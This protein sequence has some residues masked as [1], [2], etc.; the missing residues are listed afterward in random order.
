[1]LWAVMISLCAA[2]ES[3][4]NWDR[5]T[6]RL[7]APGGIYGRIAALPD[8]TLLCGYERRGACWVMHSADAGRSWSPAVEAARFEFGTAA[9]PELCVLSETTV[10]LAYNERPNDGQHP[11]TIRTAISHDAGRSWAPQALV[12]AADTRAQNGCWEPCVRKVPSG[13]LQL[14]FANESPYRASSEQE[15]SLA[16]SDDGGATWS[17]ARRIAFRSG[18]RDGM[19]VPLLRPDR[20]E[21]WLAIE[22]NPTGRKLQPE[23][24]RT[25]PAD[26]WPAETE[27]ERWQPLGLPPQVYAGAPYLA[28]LP[29]GRVLLSCQSDEGRTEP[30]MMVYLGHPEGRAF[31][32][33]SA[34]FELPESVAGR[35]NSLFVHRDGTITALSTCRIAGQ[36]GLWAIDGNASD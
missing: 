15:I 29:D 7:I 34:P 31:G 2:P 1:M 30:Q 3:T 14:Y 19:P 18:A 4:V 22:G 13:R 10:V 16:V 8:A 28:E 12:Y 21:L 17:A 9:N 6:L 5:D 20:R 26:P 32:P 11:F 23:L 33:G 35:W 36:G 25:N 27:P 24:L